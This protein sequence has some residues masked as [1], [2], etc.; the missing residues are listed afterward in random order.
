MS[1][2]VD[3]FGNKILPETMYWI[4]SEKQ[5]GRSSLR[6]AER[7]T[8]IDV[9]KKWFFERYEDPANNTPYI[10]SEGGYQFI[11][12][13]PY[14]AREVLYDEFSGIIDD[15]TIEGVVDELERI[16]SE[17][18]PSDTGEYD[19][20]LFESITYFTERYRAFTQ[21]ISHTKILAQTEVPVAQQQHLWRL[22]YVSVIIAFETY[23]SDN[24][25]SNVCTVKARLR[26]FVETDRHFSKEK[27]LLQD[28]F[29]RTDTI[30]N[31]VREYLLRFPWHRITEVRRM[32]LETLNLIFP[33]NIDSLKEAIRI[34]HD[35][36]HRGGKT[37]DGKEHQITRDDIQKLAKTVDDAVWWIERQMNPD[38]VKPPH[39][40]D[41]DLPF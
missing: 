15:E 34:R 20:E 27:I 12:G 3:L 21:V 40:D 17:W 5:I 7:K 6:K 36:V 8:Q 31:E 26:K 24:F 13:G 14:D 16:A 9:M 32:F 29:R 18:A 35:I 25:I 1:D 39:E 11:W 33:D 4:D 37:K 30:E 2:E 38:P 10:G 23:L 41:T 22:L 28:L 19:A